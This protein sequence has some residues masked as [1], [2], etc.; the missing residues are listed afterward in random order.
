ME[1]NGKDH[2]CIEV[3]AYE[4]VSSFH[5]K[6]VQGTHLPWAGWS[7]HKSEGCCSILGLKPGAGLTL[8]N[9]FFNGFVYTRPEDTFMHKQ[10]G[11]GD[12]LMGLASWCSILSLS[13]RGTMRASPWRTRPP[14]MVRVS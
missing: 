11:F 2:L 5:G 14:S 10:L 7:W 9:N 1:G 8:M 4:A 6:D 13:D 3:T 12:S